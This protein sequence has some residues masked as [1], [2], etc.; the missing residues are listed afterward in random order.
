M[1]IP[2]WIFILGGIALAI[3]LAGGGVYAGHSYTKAKY[4]KD[5]AVANKKALDEKTKLQD[6]ID[7]ITQKSHDD[8]AAVISERDAAIIRLRNRPA[9]INQTAE[10]NCK[11]TSGASLSREDAEFLTREAARADRLRG[12]LMACYSYADKL[13]E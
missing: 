4:E 13:Q 8:L 5:I 3:G 7:E 12:A 10:A 2:P 1:K 6:K 11:G 9:R